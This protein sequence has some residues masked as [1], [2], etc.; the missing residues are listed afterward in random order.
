MTTEYIASLDKCAQI[1][2][3]DYQVRRLARTFPQ[4]ATLEEVAHWAAHY[5]DFTLADVRLS[6][7]TATTASPKDPP[8]PT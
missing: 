2:P 8:D 1:G 4:S 5:G 6:V 3:D 7:N